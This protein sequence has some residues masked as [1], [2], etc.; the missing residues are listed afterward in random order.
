MDF[1]PLQ[2]GDPG[3]S[4]WGLCP[5]STTVWDEGRGEG[6]P[7][8]C[9]THQSTAGW[10]GALIFVTK[11]GLWFLQAH[12]LQLERD[13][14]AYRPPAPGS[15]DGA[16][17]TRAS[18]WLL[19]TQGSLR[20]TKTG[21]RF[22]PERTGLPA[23]T[24]G[25]RTT[26]SPVYSS[27]NTLEEI[28]SHF[29]YRAPTILS[30]RSASFITNPRA[31]HKELRSGSPGGGISLENRLSSNHPWQVTFAFIARELQA[32]KNWTMYQWAISSLMHM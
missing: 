31:E 20:F 28:I 26:T 14:K 11:M 4:G 25:R 22:W 12:K 17:V 27:I 10:L 32:E 19:C 5:D 7:C 6:C 2:F 3:A 23:E 16:S 29:L 13:L 9:H 21:S 8:K 1:L 30:L 18:P 15:P 24:W